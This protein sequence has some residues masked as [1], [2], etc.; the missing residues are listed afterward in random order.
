MPA[1]LNSD[2]SPSGP[3][4][5]HQIWPKCNIILCPLYLFSKLSL[6]FFFFFQGKGCLI[7]IYY[8]NK[9]SFENKVGGGKNCVGL[10][11]KCEVNNSP[12]DKFK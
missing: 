2:Q 12:D 6:L 11:K 3:P 4:A 8:S 10:K 7:H 5:G 9:V 1:N